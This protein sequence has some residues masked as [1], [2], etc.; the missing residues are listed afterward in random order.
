[1]A[2]SSTMRPRQAVNRTRHLLRLPQPK[3]SSN[4][5]STTLHHRVGS[6][7]TTRRLPTIRSSNNSSTSLR[8]V[9]HLLSI[10]LNLSNS[11]ISRLSSCSLRKAP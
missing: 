4:S 5:L 9:A 3:A 7:N 6:N 10:S 8:Q 11:S 2:N 1:M